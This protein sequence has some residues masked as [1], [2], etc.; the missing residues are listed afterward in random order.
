MV[1]KIGEYKI[2]KRTTT[3][4]AIECPKIFMELNGLEVRDKIEIFLD[5]N[6]KLIVKPKNGKNFTEKVEE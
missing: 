3:Q 2:M 5:D 4:Y 6:D 1:R